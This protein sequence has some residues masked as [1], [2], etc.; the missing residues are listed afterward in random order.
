MCVLNVN[1]SR[2]AAKMQKSVCSMRACVRPSF[3]SCVSCSEGSAVG[4]VE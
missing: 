3:V 1:T 4:E 2:V